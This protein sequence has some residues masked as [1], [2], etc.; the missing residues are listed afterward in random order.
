VGLSCPLSPFISLSAFSNVPSTDHPHSLCSAGIWASVWPWGTK[1]TAGVRVIT[2][3]PQLVLVLVRKTKPTE[4][5]VFPKT[6]PKPTEFGQCE[7]VTTLHWRDMYI[8]GHLACLLELVS[9]YTLT[10]WLYAPLDIFYS[11]YINLAV[12]G[13]SNARCW[14]W[15][16]IFICPIAIA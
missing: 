7:T 1:Y 4:T 10:L 2:R 11:S 13:L 14:I 8:H 6:K 16:C 5:R 9:D 12:S 15:F 3:R